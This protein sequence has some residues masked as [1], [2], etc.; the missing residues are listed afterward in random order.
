LA[1]FITAM[2]EFKVFATYS[3]VLLNLLSNAA[4]FTGPGGTIRLS[5]GRTAG[6]G[7]AFAIADIGIGMNAEEVIMALQPFR[8]VDNALSRRY[9]GTGLGLPLAQRLIELHGGKLNVESVPGQGTTVTVSS[10]QA[11]AQLAPTSSSTLPP[12]S[13]WAT[14]SLMADKG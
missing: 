4:K 10:A 6:G 5:A 7:I 11:R 8:Q 13:T 2:V 3:Q 12:R 1:D 9:E 14:A